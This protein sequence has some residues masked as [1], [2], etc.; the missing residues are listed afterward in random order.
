M[1]G[2]GAVLAIRRRMRWLV[3]L[4]L[5][6]CTQTHGDPGH[7]P[8]FQSGTTGDTLVGTPCD[9]PPALSCFVQNDFSSCDSAWYRCVDAKW[10]YEKGLGASDGQPCDAAAFAG[11]SYEGNPGCTQPTTQ[12]C[13]CGSDGLW[14]CTCGCY[15]AQWDCGACPATFP[16]TGT[17]DFPSCSD[18][19]S[20]CSYPGGH[21]CTC[22]QQTTGF[23]GKF[24][25][26]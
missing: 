19:G 2:R 22:M 10:T 9:V 15:G 17:I 4:L 3:C 14:H 12:S 25:C 13:S 7:C 5:V 16:G 1:R 21:S 11:C 6:G 18:F 23:D 24:V 26:Q 8:Q 20:T